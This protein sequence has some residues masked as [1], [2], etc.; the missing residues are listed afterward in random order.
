MAYLIG[1]ESMVR[2]LQ[3]DINENFRGCLREIYK[4]YVKK[5]VQEKVEIENVSFAPDSL[6]KNVKDYYLKAESEL[7]EKSQK[8]ILK[9]TWTKSITRF[10]RTRK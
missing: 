4:Q 7:E 8:G 5:S 10:Q 3:Y 6:R 2:T 9:Q 1:L